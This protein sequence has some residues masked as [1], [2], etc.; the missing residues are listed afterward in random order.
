M[1][2]SSNNREKDSKSKSAASKP[3]GSFRFS[4]D[5]LEAF[6]DQT[7]SDLEFDA[8]R[9]LLL[10]HC[11]NPTAQDRALQLRPLRNRKHMVRALEESKELLQ[12]KREGHPFP[13][14]G[15]EEITR[16]IEW[17]SIREAILE[18]QSFQRL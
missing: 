10:S 7:A 15:C 11:H 13:A 12:I 5:E 4:G 17:L 1:A 8:I 2:P 16:E 3:V 6:D 14:V 9:A 18:E